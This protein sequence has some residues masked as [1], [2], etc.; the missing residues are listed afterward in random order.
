VPEDLGLLF[1]R[2][3][4]HRRRLP[5][6]S[7]EREMVRVLYPMSSRKKAHTRHSCTKSKCGDG[8]T[9][10]WT[11]DC[12]GTTKANLCPG[13]ASF[14]CCFASGGSGGYPAPDIPSVG[15]CKRIAVDGAK[16]IVKQFPGKVREIGCIRPPCVSKCGE[17]GQSDHCCGMATD[18]MCSD[19]TGVSTYR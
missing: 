3:S 6:R 1:W 10:R 15:S 2:W 17:P 5:E 4:D 14:K 19:K 16:A 8:G 9:C 11:S 12:T 7:R 13:P 18:M